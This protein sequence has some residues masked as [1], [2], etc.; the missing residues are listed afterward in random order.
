M[1]PFIVRGKMVKGRG[2]RGKRRGRGGP[3]QV[4]TCVSLN[5]DQPE[6]IRRTEKKTF[7]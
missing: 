5:A 2:G 1:R 7:R 6:Q 3:Y 4:A